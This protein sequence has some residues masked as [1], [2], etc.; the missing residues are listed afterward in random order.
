MRDLTATAVYIRA[1]VVLPM[2]GFCISSQ[3]PGY[4]YVQ[5]KQTQIHLCFFFFC[6][7]RRLFASEAKEGTRQKSSNQTQPSRF[8]E[9]LKRDKKRITQQPGTL[10]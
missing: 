10:E 5:E 4:V 1:L 6:Y 8:G 7:F 3:F 2:C 9:Y